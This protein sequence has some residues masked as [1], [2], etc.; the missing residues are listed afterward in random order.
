MKVVIRT[1]AS[2]EIGTGHVMRCMTLAK[3][4]RNEGATVTFLCRNFPGNSTVY[5]AQEGFEVVCLPFVGEVDNVEWIRNNWEQDAEDTKSILDELHQEIDVLIVDHYGIDAR[6]ETKM[7]SSVNKIMVIDDLA[8]RPRDCDLL[9]D[10][11]YYLNM[12]KRYKGLIPDHCHQM[13]GPDNVL[14]RD[15]FLQGEFEPRVRTGEINNILVF[16][17]GT[18]PTG[19]TLKTLEAIR[20]I[21]IPE[22]EINVVVGGVNPKRHEIEQICSEMQNTN[23]YCQVS[24][25]AELMW[26]AD[27]AIGAG[28]STTWERCFLGLPSLTVIVAENQYEL[29][30]AISEQGTSVNIGW[31]SEVGLI[32]IKKVLT[33]IL[34]DPIQLKNMSMKCFKAMDQKKV[35]NY[36]VLKKIME[37]CF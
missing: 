27:F 24:N 6:W 26:K 1:D 23:F 28:G 34:Q 36:P 8:D 18:D 12:E 31:S 19:E 37:M 9:L 35:R 33:E 15:E 32:E 20:K 5:I 25:M 21:Y 22:I 13:I 2:I 10:Q 30:K 29:T 4:L 16:F 17:G 11:N 7:R 3:Q 14:L